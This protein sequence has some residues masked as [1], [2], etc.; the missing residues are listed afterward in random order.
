MH[1]ENNFTDGGRLISLDVF[2]GLTIALMIIVNVPGSWSSIYPPFLHANWHGITPTDLVFP[3]FLFI[4]GVSIALAYSK[5]LTTGANRSEMYR[6]LFKRSA[7]IFLLG[8]FLWIKGLLDYSEIPGVELMQ[9]LLVVL[10]VCFFLFFSDRWQWQAVI[11]LIL[12]GFSVW[13]FPENSL[14]KIRIP[15]VLQRIALVYLACALIFL[16][17][18]WKQQIWIGAS[19][20][21]GYWLIMCFIPVPIDE[22]ITKAL[23][24]GEVTAQAGELA[25]GKITA[26][27]DGFIA[28]N[29]EPGTN[30]EAW[31]D[32]KLIPGRMW[33]ITWDPEGVLSTIPS[34]GTGIMGMLCGH[35]ILSKMEQNSKLIWLF[36][37]G[38]LAFLAGCFWSW[39][40][41]I[42][43]NLWTSSYVLYTGG[44]ATLTLAT[45]IFFVDM[46]GYKKWTKFGIVF[47]ANAIM[48]YVLH[49]MLGNLFTLN[50]GT[51]EDPMRFKS[52]FMDTLTT[53]IGWDPKTASL[54]WALSYC[55]FIYTIIYALYRKK[56]FIKI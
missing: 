12:I 38:F 30:M 42:N 49:G 16:N 52:L 51:K 4:V 20:L 44:L 33:Q 19:L 55:L 40:F 46:K 43:K 5:R 7:T 31:V 53:T 48:A 11:A 32:R 41:P 37:L 39:F 1:A 18:N 25:I 3:F 45:S 24:T 29:L 28:A 10:L 13:L 8:I 2:R 56:I 14:E 21:I 26:I 35:L 27:S 9:R 15:G 36:A 17:T 23:S 22:V 6:K 47:G 34:I 54:L 50:W